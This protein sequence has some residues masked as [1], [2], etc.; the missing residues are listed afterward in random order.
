MSASAIPLQALLRNDEKMYIKNKNHIMY[1]YFAL[2]AE[3][4]APQIKDIQLSLVD[5]EP[6]PPAHHAQRTPQTIVLLSY[7]PQPGKATLCFVTNGCAQP[8]NLRYLVV[9]RVC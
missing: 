9:H 1:T 7:A 5:A 6:E 8:F 2:L 4:A 3:T